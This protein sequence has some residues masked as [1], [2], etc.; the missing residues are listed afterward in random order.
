[1]IEYNKNSTDRHKTVKT[2]VYGIRS[3]YYIIK[4]PLEDVSD[5]LVGEE[6]EML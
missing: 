6:V 1:L 3:H 5:E 4:L 2:S